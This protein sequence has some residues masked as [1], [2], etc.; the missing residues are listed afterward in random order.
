MAGGMGSQIFL[1]GVLV[2]FDVSTSHI[3]EL[4]GGENR[5]NFHN[6]IVIFPTLDSNICQNSI[7]LRRF[8]YP[9]VHSFL[10]R[11]SSI[12]KISFKICLIEH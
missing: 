2:A 4:F 9:T 6:D 7:T 10:F 8:K 12:H 5:R 11:N 1:Q 3:K